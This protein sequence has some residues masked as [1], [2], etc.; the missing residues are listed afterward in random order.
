MGAV[1]VAEEPE[2]LPA[3]PEDA[4]LAE[5][6][7]EGVVVEPETRPPAVLVLRVLANRPPARLAARHGGLVAAG[8]VVAVRRWHRHRTQHKRMAAA[9]EAAGDHAT[10]LLWRQQ[11]EAEK[12]ARREWRI[13][14][15]EVLMALAKASPWIIGGCGG[16]VVLGVL[17]A[18]AQHQ[19]SA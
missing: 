6:V 15:L 10:A 16:G 8:T 11:A 4:E 7:V 18:I 13:A 1:P 9:A 5:V 3:V 12:R 17:L 2:N 14:V 19:V